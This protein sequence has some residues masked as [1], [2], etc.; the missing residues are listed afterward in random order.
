MSALIEVHGL[1]GTHLR[2]VREGVPDRGGIH[3]GLASELAHLD[4]S[5][6]AVEFMPGPRRMPAS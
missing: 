1:L 5:P 2:V 6:K 4:G 3:Q